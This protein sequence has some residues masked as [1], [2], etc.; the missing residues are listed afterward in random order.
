MFELG[1][2]SRVFGSSLARATVT[3]GAG[4]ALT[5]EGWRAPADA[6]TNSVVA[7]AELTAPDETG[8]AA[9]DTLETEAAALCAADALAAEDAALAAADA[10]AAGAATA[11]PERSSEAMRGRRRRAMVDAGRET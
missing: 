1:C 4:G 9:T 10:L 3:S 11:D 2:H 7:T 8:L 5:E 6:L